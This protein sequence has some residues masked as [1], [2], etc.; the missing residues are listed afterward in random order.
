ME[1][2]TLDGKPEE[3]LTPL[4]RKIMTILETLPSKAEGGKNF[5][6]YRKLAELAGTSCDNIS[7]IMCLEA[8]APFKHNRKGRNYCGNAE[9]IQWLRGQP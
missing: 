3:T 8:F 4:Q 6:T 1:E 7:N 9:N 2:I 5:V